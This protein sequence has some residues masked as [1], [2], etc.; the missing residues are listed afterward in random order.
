MF[1]HT[2]FITVVKLCPLETNFANS[3]LMLTYISRCVSSKFVKK[4]I[5]AKVRH[6]DF[7]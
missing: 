7:D 2:K 3:K 6:V 1:V 4:N 5:G